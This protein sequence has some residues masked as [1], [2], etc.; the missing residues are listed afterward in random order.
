MKNEELLNYL[1]AEKY[2][3]SLA[4]FEKIGQKSADKSEILNRTKA[5]LKLLNNPEKSFKKIHI[6]GTAGKGSVSK[7]IQYQIAKNGFKCGLLTSPHATIT[8]ERI[9]INE[10]YISAKDYARI[11]E[12]LKPKIELFFQKFNLVPSFFELNFAI[13]LINF[14]EQKC[15]F[16]V[17]ETGLGGRFDCT[18]IISP[19]L[20]VI[21]NIGIDH[22]EYLGDTKEKI[23]FEKAGII[24]KGKPVFSS[25]QDP[26]IKNVFKKEADKLNTKIKYIN[27]EK[28]EILET[29]PKLIFKNQNKKYISKMLGNSQ[30]QNILLAKEV[31]DALKMD[32]KNTISC[33]LPARLEIVSKKPLIILDS[34]HNELKIENFISLASVLK[35]KKLHI[36]FSISEDKDYKTILKK[37]KNIPK[38]KVFYLCKLPSFFKK[39]VILNEMKNILANEKVK[40]FIDP[41]EALKEALKDIKNDSAI[42]STGSFFLSGYLRESFISKEKLFN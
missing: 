37:L 4:S 3:E 18:N 9:Q 7:I 29:F 36:I 12:Y 26:K 41:K 8:T 5:F 40:T 25:E 32:F 19:I 20:S 13:A 10:K 16:A 6:A 33:T 38:E 22:T 11:V 31:V 17:I 35:E 28:S 39:T 15:E 1:S 34:A 30:I 21:T 2:I 27:S 23:A 24:K 42:L 14:K